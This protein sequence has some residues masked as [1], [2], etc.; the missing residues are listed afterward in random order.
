LPDRVRRIAYL[1]YL[2]G[3]E[4]NI[5]KVVLWCWR[6]VNKK[7]SPGTVDGSVSRDWGGRSRPLV[8]RNPYRESKRCS[9]AFNITLFVLESIPILKKF[10]SHIS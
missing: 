1:I 10:L 8:A 7:K 5:L 2:R 6:C 4:G 3:L 9:N